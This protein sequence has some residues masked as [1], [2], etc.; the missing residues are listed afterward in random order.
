MNDP[1]GR[2]PYCGAKEEPKRDRS[3]GRPQRQ[4]NG[5]TEHHPIRRE[6]SPIVLGYTLFYLI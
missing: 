5:R 2:K 6:L 1:P 4:A 3:K